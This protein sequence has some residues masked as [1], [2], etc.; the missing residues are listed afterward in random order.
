MHFSSGG[1]AKKNGFHFELKYGAFLDNEHQENPWYLYISRTYPGADTAVSTYTER[2]VRFANREDA[3]AFCERVASGEL[4]LYD[5]RDGERKCE[6]LHQ[7]Q[8]RLQAEAEAKQYFDRLEELGVP[9]VSGLSVYLAFSSLSDDARSLVTNLDYV[10]KHAA[11]RAQGQREPAAQAPE[12]TLGDWLSEHQKGIDLQLVDGEGNDHFLSGVCYLDPVEIQANGLDYTDR[13]K[14]L[15]SLP[16]SY[17][18]DTTGSPVAILRTDLSKEQTDFLLGI[19]Q[20]DTS[21]W[22]ETS[23]RAVYAGADFSARLDYLKDGKPFER[24][25]D[26]NCMDAFDAPSRA[27]LFKMLDEY[28]AVYVTHP[29]NNGDTAYAYTLTK[30]QNGHVYINQPDLPIRETA[31][32][33]GLTSTLEGKL[34]WLRHAHNRDTVREGAPGRQIEHRSPEHSFR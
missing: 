34:H 19:P 7:A 3:A 29:R 18:S 17:V 28:P 13:E 23:M 30:G 27:V 12:Q 1:Y 11:L 9:I 31:P 14:W 2:S 8:L 26:G 22:G 10:T 6:A 5:I 16:V 33:Q 20:L 4:S 25:F 24:L 15:L 32:G 21:Q